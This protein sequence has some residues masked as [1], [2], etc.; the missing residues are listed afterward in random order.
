MYRVTKRSKSFLTVV[1]EGM[2][3]FILRKGS[4][5]FETKLGDNYLYACDTLSL[6]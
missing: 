5:S 4:V 6:N 2:A 3:K 1:T